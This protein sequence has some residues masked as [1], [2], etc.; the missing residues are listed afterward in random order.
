MLGSLQ[1]TK[2][3]L[4]PHH[5]VQY[6]AASNMDMQT[7]TRRAEESDFTVRDDDDNLNIARGIVLG[8]VLGAAMWALLAAF[9]VAV[10]RQG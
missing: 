3:A 1:N 2:P 8:T 7:H 6:M 10:F 9:V 5:T 4:T